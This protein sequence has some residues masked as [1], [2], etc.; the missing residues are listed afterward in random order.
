MV[1]SLTFNIPIPIISFMKCLEY[2]P[3]NQNF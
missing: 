1:Y 3:D 2:E